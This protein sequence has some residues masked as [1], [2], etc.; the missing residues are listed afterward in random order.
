M[1]LTKFSNKESGVQEPAP[2]QSV[3]QEGK[4]PELGTELLS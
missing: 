1:M 3:V 2:T 4:N